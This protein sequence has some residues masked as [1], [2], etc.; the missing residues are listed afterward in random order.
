MG[1]P[2]SGRVKR[3]HAPP[4]WLGFQPDPAPVGG[5]DATADRETQA[6]AARRAGIDR[7]ARFGGT[8]GRWSPRHPAGMPG[9]RSAT[10]TTTA[11][12]F[13]PGRYGDR[14]SGRRVLRRVLQQVDEDLLDEELIDR[15]QREI[16]RQAGSRPDARSGAPPGAGGQH[17]APP[18]AAATVCAPP[19][20]RSRPAPCPAGW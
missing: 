20:H 6:R 15:H 18:P 16:R 19:A 12:P 1:G 10:S 13:G 3:K 8:S 2:S 7:P 9:P 4:P 11:S 17:P 14:G 5:D